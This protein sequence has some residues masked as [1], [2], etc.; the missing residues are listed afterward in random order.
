MKKISGL[1]ML[2]LLLATLTACGTSVVR[3]S[4]EPTQ[5]KASVS[6]NS[7]ETKAD[8]TGAATKPAKGQ[9]TPAKTDAPATQTATTPVTLP[10]Q[11]V[12]AQTIPAATMPAQTMPAATVP[13]ATVPA[14][15]PASTGAAAGDKIVSNLPKQLKKELDKPGNGMLIVYEPQQYKGIRQ[16]VT[17]D[18]RTYNTNT[19]I[20]AVIKQK[21][22]K[23]VITDSDMAK[24]GPY[25]VPG[26]AIRTWK[27][28]TDYEVV[29]ILNTDPA[30]FVLNFIRVTEPDGSVTTAPIESTSKDVGPYLTVPY[31]GQ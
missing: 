12:P 25:S 5:T 6:Q 14:T 13:V 11:T 15:I 24:D 2:P 31:D 1:I 7:T 8:Q 3:G 20:L 26:K 16:A 30:S 10:A 22:S 21:G 19:K 23:V 27:T 29:R 9:T 18:I 4:E 17:W 28:T